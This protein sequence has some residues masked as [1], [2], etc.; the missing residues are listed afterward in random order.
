[1]SIEL[2]RAQ[3]AF[4]EFTDTARRII[5]NN[6]LSISCPFDD[7]PEDAQEH[8]ISRMGGHV[9]FEYEQSKIEEIRLRIGGY[10]IFFSF[11]KG[12]LQGNQE[13]SDGDTVDGCLAGAGVYT[14]PSLDML[15]A[16]DDDGNFPELLEYSL[17]YFIVLQ[18]AVFNTGLKPDG[19]YVEQH[20]L[21]EYELMIP[22]SPYLL[23]AT[24]IGN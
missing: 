9:S 6:L 8:A 15:K 4:S 14:V 3:Q 20:Q 1:M 16:R 11:L 2:E 21:P 10:G 13:V 17:T 24:V 19:T 22:M 23:T 12:K 5:N 18:N 7:L